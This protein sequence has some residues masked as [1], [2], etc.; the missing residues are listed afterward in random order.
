MLLI[1]ALDMGCMGSVSTRTFQMLSG[2]NIGQPPN[3]ELLDNASDSTGSE[4]FVTPTLGVGVLFRPSGMLVMAIEGG[5]VGDQA[6]CVLAIVVWIAD[7][8]GLQ[9]DNK[10]ITIKAR[11][12]FFIIF[13][14]K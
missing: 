5:A 4:V 10:Q 1:H 12:V 7:E 9:A 11:K 2:G 6:A 3:V 8:G 13:S 14:R